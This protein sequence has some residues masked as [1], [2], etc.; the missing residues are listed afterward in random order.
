MQSAISVTFGI[1][2]I[3]IDRLFTTGQ[4]DS[5]NQDKHL[6]GLTALFLASKYDEIDK[7]IPY[8]PD[9]SKISS[10]TKYSWDDVTKTEHQFLNLIHWD[11]VVICPVYFIS[12]FIEFGVIFE[13]DEVNESSF[14]VYNANK[15]VDPNSKSTLESKIKSV[16]KFAEFFVDIAFQS[17]DIQQYKYSIQALASVIAARK[18]FNIEPTWNDKYTAI[19][20]YTF[21]DIEECY[22]KLVSKFDSYFKK[23]QKKIDKPVN[24]ENKQKNVSKPI[25]KVSREKRRIFL[26]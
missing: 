8:I 20:G 15:N 17:L 25:K 5:I 9:F 21:S 13:D 2:L 4:I 3:C 24:N 18:T 11:L 26:L 12:V 6:W 14:K 1:L 10:R 23:S 19:S 7:N 16:K 22:T